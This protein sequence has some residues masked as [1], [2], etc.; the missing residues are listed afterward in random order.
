MYMMASD[1]TKSC[2]DHGV[3]SLFWLLF[4]LSLAIVKVIVLHYTYSYAY[5]YIATVKS[6]NTD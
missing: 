6:F 5:S 3:T 2:I 1:N 4:A